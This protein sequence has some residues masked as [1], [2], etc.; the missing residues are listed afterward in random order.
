MS[1]VTLS[2]FTPLPVLPP[3]HVSRQLCPP[4]LPTLTGRMHQRYCGSHRLICGAIPFRL[5]ASGS[6][7]PTLSL[8]ALRSLLPA[9]TSPPSCDWIFPKGGW[10]SFESELQCCAREVLEEAGVSGR[11]VRSL[12]EVEVR[13][14]K[15]KLGRMWMWAMQVDTE[16]DLWNDR[17]RRERRWMA[18]NEAEQAIS[19]PE[20][21]EMLHRM[22]HALADMGLLPAPPVAPARSPAEL[23]AAADD[24]DH[25]EPEPP[26]PG[27]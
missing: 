1:E 5:V 10:E 17:G 21:R 6:G 19:R 18:V 8:L 24:G 26:V 22:Q 4:L 2:P 3:P 11:L 15:G 16:F 12:G 27:A 13:S 9:A 20:M 14:G 25:S 7:P 23:E